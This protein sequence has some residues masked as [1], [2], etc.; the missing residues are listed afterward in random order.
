MQELASANGIE[1]PNLIFVGQK[2]QIP[3]CQADG[4]SAM[5]EPMLPPAVTVP[6][7]GTESGGQ[8]TG[9]Y[10]P[11]PTLSTER[12][13][14]AAMAVNDSEPA[15][16]LSVMYIPEPSP[17]PAPRIP[18][19]RSESAELI[20]EL[21]QQSSGGNADTYTVMRGDSLSVIATQF[22]TDART[23]ASVNGIDN[24]NLIY[25]GQVLRIP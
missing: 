15:G 10:I 8:P 9:L 1:N 5:P 12:P 19:A 3:G 14:A 17:R 4:P 20:P 25:A 6:V 13:Q 11:E 2:L 21:R 16:E 22:G 23:L 18:E 7:N 24:A